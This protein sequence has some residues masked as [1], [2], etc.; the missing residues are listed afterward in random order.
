MYKLD[1]KC[2]LTLVDQEINF[3][4]DSTRKYKK[5]HE[6]ISYH[7]SELGSRMIPKIAYIFYKMLDI[8]IDIVAVITASIELFHN[9]TVIHDDIID[10]DHHRRGQ[11]SLWTKYSINQAIV[12][13]DSISVLAI[14][15][16]GKLIHVEN[17]RNKF[18]DIIQKFTDY[19][20]TICEGEY[21]DIEFESQSL[22]H[23]EECLD[24]EAKKSGSTIGILLYLIAYASFNA[25]TDKSLCKI[26]EEVG[27]YIGISLQIMND[28][29]N[30]EEVENEKSDIFNQKKTIPIILALES[31]KKKEYSQYSI[32]PA[33]IMKIIQAENIIEVAKNISKK[34]MTKAL[35]KIKL[36]NLSEEDIIFSE[37]MRDFFD[38][39]VNTK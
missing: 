5:L 24:M 13:G 26:F 4:I 1:F 18:C 36:L 20:L 17:I 3:Q 27:L 10:K 8:R 29:K 32:D 37:Y 15:E 16:L 31:C 21:L 33:L 28:I 12:V 14:N 35:K 23:L 9:Y 25:D 39:N 30:I 22:V 19:T 11:Q 7:F 6:P 38:I 34:Y 2:F